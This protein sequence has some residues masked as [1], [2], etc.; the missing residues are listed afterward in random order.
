MIFL[1]LH[2]ALMDVMNT[3]NKG[4]FRYYYSLYEICIIKFRPQKCVARQHKALDKKSR[5]MFDS[6]LYQFIFCSHLQQQS[7][8]A[9]YMSERS[10]EDL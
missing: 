6:H 2:R 1:I 7:F 3:K 10:K 9:I 5:A 4:Y 8:I